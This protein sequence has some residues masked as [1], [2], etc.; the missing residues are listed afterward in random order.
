MKEFFD[1]DDDWIIGK[2]KDVDKAT[3]DKHIDYQNIET[4]AIAT[5]ITDLWLNGEI[6]IVRM[7]DGKLTCETK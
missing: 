2:W 7:I 1:S 5:S 6:L 4:K 3:M